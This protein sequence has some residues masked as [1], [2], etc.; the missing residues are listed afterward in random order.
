MCK[1]DGC[2]RKS[3][4][5]KDDVCQK[6]YFRFMRNGTYETVIK[7][8]YRISNPKGYQLLYEPNH[9]LSQE[10]GYIYE[11]RFVMYSVYG[12]NLPDCAM[13]G[14]VCSWDLYTTHIDHIDEDVTN[15]NPKNLRSLCNS[16]NTGRGKKEH[17]LRSSATSVTYKGDTKTPTEWSRYCFCTVSGATIKRRIMDGYSV[18]DA[19]LLPSKTIKRKNTLALN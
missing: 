16:C 19:I 13:C 4:Y 11:H 7:R 1:V 18:E 10:G 6:H 14:K 8:K 3:M 17:H 12:N 15:N 9:A 5:I 2:E